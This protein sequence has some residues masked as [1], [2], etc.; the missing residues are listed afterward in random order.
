MSEPFHVE[1]QIHSLKGKLDTVLIV[2]YRDSNHVTAKYR[3]SLYT[4]IYNPFAG[5]FVDD[6]YGHIKDNDQ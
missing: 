2:D 3:G 4:A 5:Y 6:L 1:A